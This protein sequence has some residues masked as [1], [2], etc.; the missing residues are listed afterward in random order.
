[1][2][3]LYK[4]HI[5]ITLL[6]ESE[7]DQAHGWFTTRNEDGEQQ[8]HY[9]KGEQAR[10]IE[11]MKQDGIAALSA[12]LEKVG[13]TPESIT[14]KH[15]HNTFTYK[16]LSQPSLDPFEQVTKPSFVVRTA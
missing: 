6:S 1:M 2:R 5:K 8:T 14:I 10:F 7:K 4:R 15:S 3:S 16:N 13:L 11:K 12:D 9:F